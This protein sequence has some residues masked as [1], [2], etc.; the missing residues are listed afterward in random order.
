MSLHFRNKDIM[1]G[2][3]KCFAQIQLGDGSSSSFIHCLCNSME[4]HQICQALFALSEAMLAF[5]KHVLMFC[6]P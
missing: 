4:G 3:V 5:T 2:S 6:V 1:P